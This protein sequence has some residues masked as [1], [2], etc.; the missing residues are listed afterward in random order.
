MDMEPQASSCSM[1]RLPT[2]A[3]RSF[4]RSK[5]A[6]GTDE[7]FA[8]VLQENTD[9][10]ERLSELEAQNEHL[11]YRLARGDSR[12]NRCNSSVEHTESDVVPGASGD[13]SPA[14]KP[15]VRSPSVRFDVGDEQTTQSSNGDA[16]PRRRAASEA[17]E[18]TVVSRSSS[19]GHSV[20]LARQLHEA[21]RTLASLSE[22]QAGHARDNQMLQQDVALIA[23]Q[24]EAM[25]VQIKSLSGA[26]E[27]SHALIATLQAQM[28][29][30]KDE[31]DFDLT[32][33][34]ALTGPMEMNGRRS[35]V[36][37]FD[38]QKSFA[39][40]DLVQESDNDSGTEIRSPRHSTAS[41][42]KLQ[43]LQLTLDW[44]TSENTTLHDQLRASKLGIFDLEQ[45]VEVQRMTLQSS[46]ASTGLTPRREDVQELQS[47]VEALQREC[48]DLAR[49]TQARARELEERGL[50]W[51][52]RCEALEKE[53]GSL[54]KSLQALERRIQLSTKADS[55]GPGT[56]EAGPS[57][58][59][60]AEAAEL[61]RHSADLE[62]QL[63]QAKRAL[64]A[65]AALAADL[66]R[67]LDSLNTDM[68]SKEVL[69]KE[70]SLP[71]VVA[72]QADK[73][74]EPGGGPSI[75]EYERLRLT[76]MTEVQNRK[77]LQKQ[78]MEMRLQ[79]KEAS[80]SS[81]YGKLSGMMCVT[82]RDVVGEDES[83]KGKAS[84]SSDVHAQG[85]TVKLEDAD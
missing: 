2:A 8:E 72:Q 28:K 71:R 61:L 79:L 46:R 64:D 4:H 29:T 67:Q 84:S 63:E 15:L 51:R 5:S 55:P 19:L 85:K 10:L 1:G 37:G 39:F 33:S 40:D 66:K 41:E 3:S 82:N 12:T 56:G 32:T 48:Q 34:L 17:E 49:Q 76:Y 68:L 47:K 65:K 36:L 60:Q 75:A 53:N 30:I 81:W 6:F 35:L 73:K 14:A 59:R 52:S 57:L 83:P 62:S 78:V 42:S 43:E 16:R 9:L 23:R 69:S 18:D 31:H 45:Q 54:Q 74:S 27:E 26:L 24:K 70:D 77:K 50:E 58:L 7:D 80:E 21:E 13:L 20:E 38:K 44:L 11:R 25:A 22:S